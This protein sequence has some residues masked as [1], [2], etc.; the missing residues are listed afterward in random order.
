VSPEELAHRVRRY[1]REVRAMLA[2][3]VSPGELLVRMVEDLATAWSSRD[4]T[5]DAELMEELLAS[6]VK[7]PI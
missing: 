2:R 5:E 6:L 1:P 4:E 3:P 7:S